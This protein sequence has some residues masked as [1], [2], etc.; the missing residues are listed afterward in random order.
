MARPFPPL[1]PYASGGLWA[2]TAQEAQ[3]FDERAIREVGVPQAALMDN[4]GRAVA[5]VI[6]RLH[7][8]GPVVG[9]VGAGNNG[10][11]ALVALRTLAAW[12][13]DTGA[14]V[15]ADRP[16]GDRLLHGW[17]VPVSV[18]SELDEAAWHERLARAEVIVDGVLGTGARGAPRPRQASAIERMNRSGRVI[19]AVDVPSGIDATTGDTPGAAVH[20]SVTV[21]FGAP[22]LGSLLHPAR[23]R[24]GRLVVVEI[25]FPPAPAPSGSALVAAPDW[26]RARFPRRGTDTHKNAV[27]RVLVVGGRLGMAGAVILGARGAF[28]AGAGLVQVCSFGDNRSAIQA[29]IPEA[30]FV[31]AAD[32]EAVNEA[33]ASADGLVVGPG[34]GTDAKAKALLEAVLERDGIATV[35]DADALNL[36]AESAID[37]ARIGP[38]RPLLITP[39]PGE[40]A[41]L[42]PAPL[43]GMVDRVS[44]ARSAAAAFSCHVLLKGAPSLV[45]A[46]GGTLWVDTQ[47]SSDLAVA[48]MGDVLAGVCASLLAQG[49]EPASA[50]AVGLYLS[51]RAARLAG[52]GAGL[53]PADV[54]RWLPDAL[55]ERG[56]SSTDL[57]IPW[58]V[59]DADPAA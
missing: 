37:L 6:Q 56:T 2:Q 46:P 44:V 3:D 58:V 23:A 19:V 24:T 15:V 53:T 43:E 52:R 25:G 31:D 27:G 17:P 41:R 32:R 36:A 35:L 18:D 38:G 49:L 8:D 13:R 9:I 1:R 54:V 48:G 7:P 12:G 50:A 4:A 10:G 20:A 28:R 59:F 16:D 14:V 39:H 40:M 29:A 22:K 11:D 21:S 30:L 55:V 45:A 42:R 47:S 34:L 33:V 26:A 51:G 57:D 5:T